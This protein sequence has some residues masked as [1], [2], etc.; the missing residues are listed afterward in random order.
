[1]LQDTL[2][3]QLEV[4]S[5]APKGKSKATPLLF[6]HGAFTAAWCWDEYF[7]PFFAQHGYRAHA[8]SLRGHG[9]SGGHE[10]LALASIEDYVE[11]VARTAATLGAPPV[12]IGHSMGGLVVQKY[13]QAHEAPAAILMAPV[14]PQGILG[15][16][17]RMAI[18][19]PLFF[20]EIN[21]IQNAG[22]QDAAPDTVRRA[23]FSPAMPD[24]EIRKHV[25][26]MQPESQRAIFDLSWYH[27]R[28]P[29]QKV[30]APLLVLGAENDAFFPR[31]VVELTAQTYGTR[32]EI[33]PG[34]AHAMMLERDWQKV[35]RRILEWLHQQDL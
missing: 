7:L 22:K 27:L 31:S 17:M 10:F 25:L 35:A 4:I 5:Q 3:I 30:R 1:M 34:M 21:L 15:S 14:P 8:L 18:R 32:A 2:S 28:H 11:D 12:L 29:R 6:V 33:F 23:L 9:A 24:D 19:D 13:L 16:A 26:R 20:H